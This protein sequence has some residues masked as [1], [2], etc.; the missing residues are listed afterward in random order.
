M[1]PHRRG[2]LI[3]LLVGLLAT[4]GGA[5]VVRRALDPERLRHI[6]EARM[7][8]AI[9]QPVTIGT[10]GVSF[11][12][13]PSV[14]AGDI[15]VG[16]GK[17]IAGRAPSVDVRALRIHPKLSSIFSSPVV[18]DRVEVLGL[19]I[20][21]RRDKDGHWL[22]PVTPVPGGGDG[23]RR[24]GKPSP[25]DVN[26]IVLRDGR[27]TFFSDAP[28][29][30]AGVQEAA[31]I[32]DLVATVRLQEGVTTVESMTAALGGSLLTGQGSAG[33]GGLKFSLSWTS[34]SAK[35]LPEVFALL[36][37]AA[38]RGLV[39]QGE[40]PLVLELTVDPGGA[41]AATGRIAADHASLGTLALTALDA[42][43]RYSNRQL[44]LDPVTFNTY[45]GSHRG[46]ITADTA[47][48]PVTWTLD[49]SMDRVDVNRLVSANS[50]AKGAID[51]VGRLRARL[52][53][54]AAEPVLQTVAGTV[55]TNVSNGAIHNFPLVAAVNAALKAGA[56]DEKDLRFDNLSAT[57]QVANLRAATSDLVATSGELRLTAAGRLGFDQSLDFNGRLAF[58]RAKSDELVR[59]VR[60]LAAVRGA[61]GEIEVPVTVTGTVASPAFEVDARALLL[62]A[63]E[64]ELKRRLRKGLQRIIK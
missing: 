51:G 57:W 22:L 50:S 32:R 49:S 1:L 37:A 20:R 18:I 19:A 41:P 58:S 52:R 30:A 61:D 45:G 34:L 60:E 10:I 17:A 33:P 13:T 3:V 44:V 40:K 42:P 63:A 47:A 4:V 59:R 53:G 14:E 31:T 43:L 5:I 2:C 25:V 29:T 24:A 35:D 15:R 62:K 8:E 54:S 55:V 64:E 56:G 39:V 46:R 36:G 12:P 6:A 26:E 9:G 11:W 16:S 27:V 7:G 38:P 28:G 23:V 21:V 48:V